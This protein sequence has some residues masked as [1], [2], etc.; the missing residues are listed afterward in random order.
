[1][2]SLQRTFKMKEKIIITFLMLIISIN[3]FTFAQESTTWD[4]WAPCQDDSDC[5]E[6]LM[7][8]IWQ[9]RCTEC[10]ENEDCPP[11]LEADGCP[12][13]GPGL[14][15]YGDHCCFALMC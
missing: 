10:V 12:I 7:C 13:P 3:A 4:P 9:N 14:C 5:P 11:C 6:H 1:M 8:N 15:V 2:G